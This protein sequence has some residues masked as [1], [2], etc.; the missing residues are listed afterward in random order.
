MPITTR[1]F[2]HSGRKGLSL[3]YITKVKRK[4]VSMSVYVDGEEYLIDCNKDAFVSTQIKCL[5]TGRYIA[6]NLDRIGKIHICTCRWTK[7]DIEEAHER[8]EILSAKLL[9]IQ[10]YK[11]DF[12]EVKEGDINGI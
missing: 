10:A 3:G 12:I 6:I 2:V 4:R 11:P 7:K 1:C 9:D 5:R 8:A